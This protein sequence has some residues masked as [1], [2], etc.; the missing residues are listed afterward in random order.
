M[1]V[2]IWIKCDSSKILRTHFRCSRYFGP[3][4]S[5]QFAALIYSTDGHTQHTHISRWT[6]NLLILFIMKISTNSLR[7]RCLFYGFSHFGLIT[8]TNKWIYICEMRNEK[9]VCNYFRGSYFVRGPIVTVWR[10]VL[11]VFRIRTNL[12]FHEICIHMDECEFNAWIV[13]EICAQ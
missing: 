6:A 12:L 11:S 2:R 5:I 8:T 3:R 4:P 10:F 1:R 13:C 7:R 9:C